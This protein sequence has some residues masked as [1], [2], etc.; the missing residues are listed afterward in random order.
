MLL[1]HSQNVPL[2][3]TT[4]T[5][6][7]YIQTKNTKKWIDLGELTIG[8]NSANVLRTYLP[9]N[10]YPQALGQ[11]FFR[12][13]GKPQRVYQFYAD[14]SISYST[15][16]PTFTYLN[17]LS[18]NKA[19]ISEGSSFEVATNS[20]G[21]IDFAIGIPAPNKNRT[22]KVQF[23]VIDS[24]V[25]DSIGKF[26]IGDESRWL[27]YLADSAV[28][29]NPQWGDPIPLLNDM[30]S[31]VPKIELKMGQITTNLYRITRPI[32][33]FS[34]EN[35]R[36]MVGLISNPQNF[37]WRGGNNPDTYRQMDQLSGLDLVQTSWTTGDGYKLEINRKGPGKVYFLVNSPGEHRIAEF[38]IME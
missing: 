7:I 11:V 20:E 3:G 33:D 4:K 9:G 14:T 35:I 5:N 1:F 17:D 28:S 29:S 16:V 30:V 25:M 38:F 6:H 26:Y 12:F 32:Y 23:E 2:G 15:T 37:Q 34:Q 36:G 21:Y 27:M 18:I 10:E 22:C 24:G 19:H 8:N 31:T 13:V